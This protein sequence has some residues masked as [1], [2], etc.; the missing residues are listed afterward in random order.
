[1]SRA[2]VRDCPFC[3]GEARVWTRTSF[4]RRVQRETTRTTVLCADC[5]CRTEAHPRERDAVAL[6]NQR[7]GPDTPRPPKWP[8]P[9]WARLLGR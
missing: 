6:W 2:S 8:R 5:G 9:W 7:V 4:D 3:G 1:M